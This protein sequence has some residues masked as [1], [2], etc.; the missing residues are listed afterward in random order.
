MPTDRSN[1]A[2][3]VIA[4]ALAGLIAVVYP[5]VIPALTVAVAV[6]GLAMLFLKL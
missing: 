1:V 6:A 3:V 2:L 4:A 5:A